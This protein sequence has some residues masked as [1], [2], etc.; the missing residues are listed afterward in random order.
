MKKIM[1]FAM[2]AIAAFAMVSCACNNTTEE[3][4][5]EE[6]VVEEVVEETTECE[7]TECAETPATEVAPE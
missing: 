3:V 1:M 7:N 5:T 2:G 4:A 6:E